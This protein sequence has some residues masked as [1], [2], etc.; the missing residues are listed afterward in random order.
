MNSK[1]PQFILASDPPEISII[2]PARNAATTLAQTLDSVKAQTFQNWE[3]IIVDDGSTDATRS[4][5]RNQADSDH[6]ILTMRGPERGVS[7]ARN[8]GINAARGAIIAFLDAD[9]LWDPK[10]LETHQ[11]HLGKRP[12][13]GISFARVLFVDEQGKSTGVLSAK[14]GEH[15]EASRLLYENP[16]C[17]AST[18]VI[19]R[20]LLHRVGG[21]D[22]SMRFSEDLELMVRIRLLTGALIEGLND[23]L[24]LY[25]ASPKGA[26]ADLAAMQAGWETLMQRVGAYAPTLIA[27][28][29]RCARATHLRYLSRRALRLG[30]PASQGLHL[31]SEAMRNSTFELLRQPYRTFGTLAALIVSLFATSTLQRRS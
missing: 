18:L 24:T 4:I 27:K 5:I 20:E 7:A 1:F 31:F 15:I 29:I 12:A 3:C 8:A 19:R 22:E 13:V 30:L 14:N 25:R 26:S 6:R 16:A 21:F 23:V 9:D 2:I 10:K 28:H 17:T 11:V